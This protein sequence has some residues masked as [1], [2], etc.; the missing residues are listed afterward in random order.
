MLL[1]AILF[2]CSENTPNI[3]PDGELKY[4]EKYHCWPYDVDVY[5]V[6]GVE[7]DSLF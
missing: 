7:V 6:D 2:G 3:L 1:V 5:S 4:L